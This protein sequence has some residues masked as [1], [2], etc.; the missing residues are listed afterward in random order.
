MSPRIRLA[1]GAALLLGLAAGLGALLARPQAAR[2]SG[3]PIVLDLRA[4][5]GSPVTAAGPADGAASPL[6]PAGPPPL[7]HEI[8]GVRAVPRTGPST[9]APAGVLPAEGGTIRGRARIPAELQADSWRWNLH[10]RRSF[11]LLDGTATESKTLDL[12][13][14]RDDTYELVGLP[15]GV[16]TLQWM[17]DGRPVSEAKRVSLLEGAV[18]AGQDFTFVREPRLRGHVVSAEDD[19]PL[20][21]AVIRVPGE[22]GE[23]TDGSG[24]FL[25]RD[26]PPG[27]Q[28]LVVVHP[29][30]APARVAVVVP[31][32]GEAPELRVA[33]EP[34]ASARVV[35]LG[36]KGP[37]AGI[38]V[39]LASADHVVTAVTGEDGAV[40]L[41]GLAP[42]VRYRLR[43]LAADLAATRALER[44][45]FVLVPA[46]EEV[47]EITALVD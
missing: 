41:E 45:E 32:R 37:K 40:L 7:A 19:H 13:L 8:P 28:E 36:P 22:A 16:Y 21:G 18:A 35:V 25:L 1:L 10:L 26:L 20:E 15:A 2:P 33:L 11:D 38:T 47:R 9:E 6:P 12:P 14:A 39:M 3:P 31:E 17:L 42:G 34:G 4:R 30:H 43:L 24:A 29:D 44:S 46:R 23:R 27:A 5:A